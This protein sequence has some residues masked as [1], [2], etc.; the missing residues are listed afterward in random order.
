MSV[1]K[2]TVTTDETLNANKNVDTKLVKNHLRLESE[3]HRL[4]IDTKPTYNIEPALG[5]T[6]LRSKT[7]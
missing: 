7:I 2:K 6:H 4:G 5:T 1:Q 3:L